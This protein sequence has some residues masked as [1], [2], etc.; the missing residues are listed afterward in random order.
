MRIVFSHPGYWPYMASTNRVLTDLS[1][2]LAGQGHEVHVICVGASRREREN[3]E[4]LRQ[5]IVEGVH[6]HR[7]PNF[8]I[9]PF[10]AKWYS[11]LNRIAHFIRSG[12][13]TL[14]QGRKAD[15]VVTLDTPLLMGWWGLAA[16]WLSSGRAKHI[17]WSMDLLPESRFEMGKWGQSNPFYRLLA[18]IER[19]PQKLGATTIVLGDCMKQRLVA[20]GVSDDAVKVAG[21]W[22][23]GDLVESKMPAGGAAYLDPALTGKFLLLYSGYTGAAHNVGPLLLL[24]ERLERQSNVQI[25]LV[26]D[27]PQLMDLAARAQNSGLTNLSRFNA[28]SWSE[29]GEFPGSANLHVVSLVNSMT[30][31]C[32]PSKTYGRLAPGRP[33]LF[34]GSRLSQVAADI[35]EARA[36]FVIDAEDDEGIAAQI[37]RIVNRLI[38]KPWLAKRL[39]ANGRNAF[40]KRHDHAVA[41]AAWE[42]TLLNVLGRQSVRGPAVPFVGTNS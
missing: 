5:K 9:G 8:R 42:A 7:I 6:V 32:V 37:L 40:M 4:R 23:Y 12:I 3:D 14:D 1:R 25:A 10:E 20:S 29:L 16:H 17:V 11:P 35:I 39:G 33:T 27:S 19:L 34:I 30:G 18:I 24:A 41:C 13:R 21:I 38:Q 15:V 22:H 31:T 36:G 26:D 28:R 2:Y